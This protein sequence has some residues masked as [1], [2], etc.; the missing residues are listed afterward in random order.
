METETV[1]ESFDTDSIFTWL[2]TQ[3]NSTKYSHHKSFKRYSFFC[4]LMKVNILF[5]SVL[6]P[7]MIRIFQFTHILDTV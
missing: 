7:F 1:S 3:E 4:M 2:I 5:S 6:F